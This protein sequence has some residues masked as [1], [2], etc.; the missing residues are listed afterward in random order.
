MTT[1]RLLAV[2]APDSGVLEVIRELTGSAPQPD[3][4]GSTAGLTH[5]WKVK[6]DYYNA[7][8]PVWIDEIADIQSWKT[9]FLRPEAKE[10]IDAIGAWVYCFRTDQA[11]KMPDA[12]EEAMKAFQEISEKHSQYGSDVAMLA[13][14]RPPTGSHAPADTEAE[15]D[16]CLQYGFEYINASAHGRNNFSEN[17]GI[18]RLKE[19]LEANEWTASDGDDDDFLDLDDG[20]DFDDDDAA[21]GGFGAVEAEMASELFGMKAALNDDAFEPD[22]SETLPQPGEDAHIEDLDRLMGRI[23][24]IKEQSADLPDSERKRL[25]ARVVKDLMK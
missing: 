24:A 1:R 7:T 3:T 16:I 22:A 10:V 12:A 9:E 17:V 20:L 4:T 18:E 25:A 15:E 23:M 6:T 8:V 19:A 14:A 5:E 21:F 13:V 2:G 11:G